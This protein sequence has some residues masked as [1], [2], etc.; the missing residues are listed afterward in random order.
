MSC[1]NSTIQQNIL[2]SPSLRPRENLGSRRGHSHLGD[3]CC[4]CSS[5]SS[6]LPFGGGEDQE[7]WRAGSRFTSFYGFG[8]RREKSW[9]MLTL[10]SIQGATENHRLMIPHC[11][12]YPKLKQG[13][14][15]AIFIFTFLVHCLVVI[16]QS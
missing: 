6:S 7:R 2:Q 3:Y 8:K 10:R 12:P 5:S 11:P 13:C 9:E 16:K 4:C 14:H 1:A 15:R